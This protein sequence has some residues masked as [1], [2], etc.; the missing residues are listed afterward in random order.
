MQTVDPILMALF[1]LNENQIILVHVYWGII[2]DPGFLRKPWLTNN[3]GGNCRVPLFTFVAVAE[4][5]QLVAPPL[6]I[7]RWVL[8]ASQKVVMWESEESLRRMGEN[9]YKSRSCVGPRIEKEALQ[10]N[11][12]NTKKPI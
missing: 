9:I 2:A 4:W 3:L 10:L 5:G 1:P 6:D 12:K 7:P 8:V 11:N